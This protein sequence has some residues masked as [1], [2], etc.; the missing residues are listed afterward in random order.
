M[1]L[2]NP[3][4]QGLSASFIPPHCP[5]DYCPSR[6][7]NSPF[8]WRRKG[9]YRRE[10]D[11][12]IVQRFLC[13]SCGSYFSTQAFRLDYRL[14]KPTLHFALFDTFVSKVTQ[15]QAARNLLC[16][17]KTVVHRLVLL[18]THA[19]AFHKELLARAQRAGGIPGEFQ[20]DELETF[21]NSRRLC[22]V[23]MP[24]LIEQGS[25]F[26]LDI[27]VAT[28]PARG[29]P[30]RGEGK[31]R[32]ERERV[33]GKR[34]NESRAA[35]ERCF[36]VLE[37]VRPPGQV[38]SISSDFK[39]SYPG[40]LRDV[41]S[42]NY[43]HF[44]HSSKTRRD[45]FNPLFPINHTLAMLRDGLSRLVRRSW[46]AS[47]QREWLERHAWIWIAY[48]NYIRDIF[49]RVRRTTSAQALGVVSRQFSKHSLFEWKVFS[50]P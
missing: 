40:V 17:R 5:R 6:G 13:R 4:P 45:R 34:K 23:T 20:L 27:Q 10:C 38:L 9:R 7:A 15:R 3:F 31:K 32:L 48:R 29:K 24:V 21:E 18:S 36:R 25:Y 46:G 44:R 33:E 19:R 12:R 2:E 43:R 35:V 50:A 22:P 16:T 26:A 49:N 1:N 8:R 47:K 42:P 28:L 39:S 30:H 11:E 37:E 41:M 14:H